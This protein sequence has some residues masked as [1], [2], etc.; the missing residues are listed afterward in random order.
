MSNERKIRRRPREADPEEARRARIFSDRL[1][2]LIVGIPIIVVLI[3][4]GWYM[5]ATDDAARQPLMLSQL[6]LLSGE[7][8]GISGTE[9]ERFLW[10]SVDE[11]RKGV[12]ITIDQEGVLRV[13]EKG[14]IVQLDV[15]PRE[16]GASVL[17]LVSARHGEQL[18][19]ASEE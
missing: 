9:R 13:L 14:S 6:Q 4:V 12:R 7:Y 16:G 19:I 1:H 2:S 15:A 18:L 5:K 3:A 11:K 10:L 8:R 17:W